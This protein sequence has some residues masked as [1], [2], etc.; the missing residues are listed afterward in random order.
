MFGID[1]LV[2]GA[3]GMIPG[4]QILGVIGM[5]VELA[6]G[7][8]DK[9]DMQGTQD[10]LKFLNEVVSKLT[11]PGG[12]C[13]PLPFTNPSER[14][15]AQ[16]M[17]N[18][19]TLE[20]QNFMRSSQRSI[21]ITIDVNPGGGAGSGG[22]GSGGGSA[23]PVNYGT[24]PLV[25]GSVAGDLQI[26]KLAS[27]RV[28]GAGANIDRALKPGSSEWTTV[29]W[30]MQQNP[31]VRYNADTK[32][33]TLKMTDGTDRKLCTL[34]EAQNST[35]PAGLNRANPAGSAPLAEFLNQRTKEVSQ[36]GGANPADD[37]QKLVDQLKK[38]LQQFEEAQKTMQQSTIDITI[39][40]AVA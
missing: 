6:K 37:I 34:E 19:N 4:G 31:N 23:Q 11:Q 18:A 21:D 13:E 35:G 14:G 1:N 25:D 36:G 39:N 30:A 38:L 10:V 29:M 7:L 12:Q 26:S 33:F 2:G 22:A 15:S 40:Q 28:D 24:L 20:N 16:G 3:A 17:V 9:G 5:G 8:F 32:E 27:S